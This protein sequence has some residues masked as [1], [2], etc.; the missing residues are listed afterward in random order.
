MAVKCPVDPKTLS[1]VETSSSKDTFNNFVKR[2]VKSEV[3]I[4]FKGLSE[5]GIQAGRKEIDLSIKK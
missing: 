2:L 4:V 5:E 1:E 3:K